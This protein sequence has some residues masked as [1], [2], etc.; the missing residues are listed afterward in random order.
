MSPSMDIQISSNFERVLYDAVGA[1]PK[2]IVDA[3]ET[4]KS[5]KLDSKPLSHLQ[6]YF[7]A[8]T[9]DEAQTKEAIQ[10]AFHR[11]KLIIDPHTAVGYYCALR[12]REAHPERGA[13]VHLLTVAT[14]HHGKFPDAVAEV[15]G[16]NIA[17][18]DTPSA[19][20]S[21]GDLPQ[22][23]VPMSKDAEAVGDYLRQQFGST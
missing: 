3:L 14:A 16:A 12:Y 8:Y 15:V 20:T 5:F 17:S 10:I 18:E 4:S 7:E 13:K 22:R 1:D 6:S 11:H 9:A 19:L 23:F 2:F 21:L